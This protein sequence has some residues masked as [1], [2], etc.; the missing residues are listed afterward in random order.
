MV[1]RTGMTAAE[2]FQLPDSSQPIELL[3]GEVIVSPTPIPAHQRYVGNIFLLLRS[4]VP[5]GEVFIAPLDVRLDEANVPQSDVMWVAEGSPCVITD[6]R[7]EG[8]P[9][10]VV[11]VFSP[12]TAKRDKEDKFAL[13]QRHGVR[14][15]W[16]LD[17]ANRYLEAWTLAEGKFNK[18]GTFVPGE[19]FDSPVLGRKTVDLTTIFGSAGEA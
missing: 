19:T 8:P 6:K 14:E 12:S 3:D 18:L 11:E 10:L 13:Y 2:F 4:I 17:P 9:D 15:Y 16:M 5:N 1:E 7:L